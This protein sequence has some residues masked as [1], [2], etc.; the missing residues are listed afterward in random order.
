[1]DN[2][3][4][5]MMPPFGAPMHQSGS[6]QLYTKGATTTLN[7]VYQSYLCTVWLRSCQWWL[8]PLNYTYSVLDQ[9]RRMA[10]DRSPSL[11]RSQFVYSALSSPK[12]LPSPFHEWR[13][14]ERLD[15]Y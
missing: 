12:L 15:K 7:Y 2:C 1:M 5:S 14:S 9:I 3:A 10:G 6:A 13:P 11:P 8:P 4:S